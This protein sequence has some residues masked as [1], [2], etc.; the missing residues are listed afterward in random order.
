MSVIDV[1]KRVCRHGT[2]YAVAAHCQLP[3]TSPDLVVRAHQE[4]RFAPAF[5]DIKKYTRFEHRDDG[6]IYTAYGARVGFIKFCM[7]VVKRVRRDPADTDTTVIEFCTADGCLA[8]F[9]GEWRVSRDKNNNNG[10]IV[11]L[12][13]TVSAPSWARVLPVE[14]AIRSRVANAIDDMHALGLANVPEQV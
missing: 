4:E 14:A 10:S 7:E 5:R 9:R 11:S 12:Q 2:E 1:T 6:R 8:T 13:Q 3:L